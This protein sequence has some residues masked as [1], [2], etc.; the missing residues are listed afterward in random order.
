[1]RGL[2]DSSEDVRIDKP[3]RMISLF[4]GYGSP[5]MALKRLGVNFEHHFMCEFDKYAVKSYNAVHGT[6]FETSDVRNIHGSDLNITDSDKYCYM[7]TYSF[8]CFTGETLVLTDNGLKQIK[9]VCEGESVISHDGAYH[10]IIASK[11]AG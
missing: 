2:F 6:D 10:K 3:I 8:P 1:M 7:L 4:A 5:E 11:K 9:D